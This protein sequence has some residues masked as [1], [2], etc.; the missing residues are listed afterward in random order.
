MTLTL[1]KAVR[2]FFEDHLRV[3]K[4][5]RPTSIRSYRDV[6]CLFLNFVSTDL[7]RPIT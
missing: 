6:V 2:S 7:H 3:Q 4:G 5:L 1:G